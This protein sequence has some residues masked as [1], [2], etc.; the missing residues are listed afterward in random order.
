MP[1]CR[2]GL[3]ELR[4]GATG[5]VR[6]TLHPTARQGAHCPRRERKSPNAVPVLLLYH[7]AHGAAGVQGN[8]SGAKKLCSHPNAIGSPSNSATR[9]SGD[10]ARWQDFAHTMITGISHVD[11]PLCICRDTMGFTKGS[12]SAQAI[13]KRCTPRAS[14]GAHQAS[15]GDAPHAVPTIIAH[16]QA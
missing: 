12:S 10:K 5:A 9:K 3:I 15:G 2:N 7:V 6:E 1:Y 8:V 4:Q 13:R 16:S 11:N 14:Q